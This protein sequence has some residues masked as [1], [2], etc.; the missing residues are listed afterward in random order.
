MENQ[1]RVGRILLIVAGFLLVLCIGMV[2]GGAVVYGALRIGD[3]LSSRADEGF[4]ERDIEEFFDQSVIP[5]AVSASG[6]V[7]AEVMPGSPAEEAGLRVG[8][9]ILA[10]DSQQPGPDGTL[11][12]LIGQYEPGDRVT[13]EAQAEDGAVR[14]VRVRLGE[15]PDVPGAPYLGV[16]YQPALSPEM[17]LREM[18]PFNDEGELQLDQLPAPLRELLGGGVMVVSVTE[19]SPADD[20]GLQRGDQIASLDGEALDSA[21]ALIDAIGQRSPGDIVTLGVLRS[22]DQARVELQIQLDEHP[23]RAGEPYLG[24]TVSDM[25]RYH[26][27]QGGSYRFQMTPEPPVP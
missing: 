21:Q 3:A 8:D 17:P 10:V 19:G 27:F 6:A 14:L 11:G 9:V 7:I 2:I 12:D 15:N 25:M 22:G 26:R 13:L 4:L 24:V 18:L 5:E 16:R 20:A 23:D 1:N